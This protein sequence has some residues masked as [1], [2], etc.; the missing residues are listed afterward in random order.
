MADFKKPKS[1]GGGGNN[2]SL[3]LLVFGMLAISIFYFFTG[4]VSPIFNP[5]GILFEVRQ[6]FSPII[7]ENLWWLEILAIAFSILF[8]W[9]TAYII[10]RTNYLSIKREQYLEVFGK[11]HLSRDR[12]L[13]AWKQILEKLNSEDTNNWRMAI[14]ESDHILNEI[15]KMSGYLGKM[16]DKLPKLTA[17]QLANIEDVRRAHVVRDKIYRDPSFLI[18]REEAIEVVKIY[19]QSFRELNLIRD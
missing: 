2:S 4:L 12:S 6:Y 5:V 16:D 9:G 19:E 7:H 8:L 10:N 13:R 3:E 18:T 1:G 17:E 15:L 14:L 11:D